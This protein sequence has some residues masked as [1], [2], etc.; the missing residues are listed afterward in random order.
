MIAPSIVKTYAISTLS[1]FHVR[2]RYNSDLGAALVAYSR[3][4]LATDSPGGGGSYVTSHIPSTAALIASSSSSYGA[5]ISDG[6]SGSGSSK[7][8]PL[9]LCR[10]IDDIP[11]LHARVAMN[12]LLFRPRLGDV[13][14]GRVQFLNAGLIS[15]LVG[16]LFNATIESRIGGASTTSTSSHQLAR[17]GL[18][19]SSSSSSSLPLQAVTQAVSIS[20]SSSSSSA[21]SSSTHLALA[22]AYAFDETANAWVGT[23]VRD[24]IVKAA[25]AEAAARAGGSTAKSFE[26]QEKKRS[27]KEMESAPLSH[28]SAA[29]A[30]HRLVAANPASIRMGS[31]V[32]FRVTGIQSR[33]G[34][35][36]LQGSLE[37]E[38]VDITPRPSS[39]K[40]KGGESHSA[41]TA[42]RDASSAP[43]LRYDAREEGGGEEGEGERHSKKAKKNKK[44]REEER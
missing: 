16:G 15:M 14:K 19:S 1:R 6:S 7:R 21:S 22:G 4:R 30:Y 3:L 2:S 26:K 11:V 33:G 18:A 23:P 41:E 32:T 34:V 28:P 10:I 42:R 35:V 8:S 29:A 38:A 24:A 39:A 37:E 12:A 36:V 13:V 20:S 40:S 25:A 31:H 43:S 9:P 5:A 44:N 17:G 27:R